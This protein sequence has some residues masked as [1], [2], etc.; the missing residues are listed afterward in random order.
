MFINIFSICLVISVYLLGLLW[1]IIKYDDNYFDREDALKCLMW[2]LILIF[3]VILFIINIILSLI[4]CSLNFTFALFNLYFIDT[5]L[6]RLLD[7]I[8]DKLNSFINIE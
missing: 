1:N 7:K 6:Y 8:I 5:K 4:S 3:K 2:P